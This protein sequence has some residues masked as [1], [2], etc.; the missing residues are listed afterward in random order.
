MFR[1]LRYFLVKFHQFL[2]TLWVRNLCY[3]IGVKDGYGSF[4]KLLY[5][6][7]GLEHLGDV[8]WPLVFDKHNGKFFLHIVEEKFLDYCYL[9]IIRQKDI[10]FK[11]MRMNF[12]LCSLLGITYT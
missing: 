12:W 11:K 10:F 9:I 8:V 2:E 5:Y 4:T 3:K 7:S 1:L 6:Q